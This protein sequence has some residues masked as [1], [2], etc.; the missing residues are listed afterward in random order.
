MQLVS[1][2]NPI[3]RKYGKIIEIQSSR[4]PKLTACGIE[5]ILTNP[6]D[7]PGN[8]S[9]S[10]D[11]LDELAKLKSKLKLRKKAVFFR[12]SGEPNPAISFKEP[13]NWPNNRLSSL[14]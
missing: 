14:K 5:D 9:P 12:L 8:A 2:A 10:R 6:S 7:T 11:L 13:G 4:Q 3:K 1:L